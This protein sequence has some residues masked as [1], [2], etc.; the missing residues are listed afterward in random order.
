[1]AEHSWDLP[2]DLEVDVVAVGSGMG[3]T[4]AAIAAQARGQQ[5][6]VLEKADVLGGGT[7]YSYGIV[8]VGENHFEPELGVEDTRDEAFAYLQHLGAG[9]QNDVNLRTYVDNAPNVLR[10]F[11]DDVGVPFYAVPNFPDYYHGMAPGSRGHGRNLQVKP[12]QA[13]SLGENQKRLRVAPAVT[14]RAT[15]EEIASWGGRAKPQGWDRELIQ[16]RIQQDVRTFGAGLIGHLI[17]AA[18]QRGIPMHTD[19]PVSS[20][21]VE[22]GRVVGVVAQQNG[23]DLRIRARNAVVLATGSYNRNADL[24]ARFNEIHSGKSVLPPTIQGDSLIIA[25]EIGAAIK[26]TPMFQQDLVYAIPGETHDG[27]PLYRG[28]TNNESGFPHSILVNLDGNRFADESIG[29]EVGVALRNF[30]TRR[31]RYPNVPCFLVFDQTYLDKYGL[32]SVRPGQDAPDWLTRSDSIEGLAEALGVDGKGLAKTIQRFNQ[33]AKAGKDED[34][35][36]GEFPFANSVSG[37]LTNTPNPNM[38][39]LE[40]PP[41]YG[42][43][44]TPTATSSAGL[45]TNENAQV[46]HLRGNPIPG[47]YACGSTA[48]HYYGIGYQAGCELGGG[49]TFGY[50]AVQHASER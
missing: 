20:L 5:A 38:G 28:A 27:G 10:F 6:I 35:G 3:G 50:L 9:H 36:R 22:D 19:A 8:W 4:C 37:D 16:Q 15:F 46:L 23:A 26:F 11:C 1:M 43:P 40:H 2:W 49:M 30:D 21:V 45:M 42:L 48:A 47:L 17:H 32:G 41:Y 29:Q 14:H 24:T 13:A 25:G 18:L 31:H 34:F 7:T 33:F 39:P 12:F 44:L